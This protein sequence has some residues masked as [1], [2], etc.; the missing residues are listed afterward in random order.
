MQV[1]A[2]SSGATLQQSSWLQ[3]VLASFAWLRKEAASVE[4]QHELLCMPV[5]I[6]ASSR[7]SAS[8]LQI[9]A[10]HSLTKYIHLCPLTSLQMQAVITGLAKCSRL[11]PEIPLPLPPQLVLLLP[12][13]GG[14]PRLLSQT[15]CLLAGSGAV[16]NEKFPA[17]QHIC[18]TRHIWRMACTCMNTACSWVLQC[19]VV[20]PCMAQ[21]GVHEA[22]STYG[23]DPLAW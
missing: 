17:G 22:Y 16:H 14:N 11:C 23:S 3:T 21:L 7:A 18:N 5:V 9:T 10:R 2:T 15:L 6:T 13:I 20:A 12:L 4:E 8:S 19:C 1:G